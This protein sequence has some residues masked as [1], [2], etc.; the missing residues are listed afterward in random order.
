MGECRSIRKL[1]GVGQLMASREGKRL[2]AKV[3]QF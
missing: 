1:K 3:E 2:S